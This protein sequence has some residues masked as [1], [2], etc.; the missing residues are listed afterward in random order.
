MLAAKINYHTAM[1]TSFTFCS[2]GILSLA[3]WLGTAPVSRADTNFVVTTPNFIYELN[4]VPPP[5]APGSWTN[6]CEPLTLT[7]GQTVTFNMQASFFHPM[8][9]ATNAATSSLDPPANFAYD[10]ASPQDIASGPITLTLSASGFPST[11][12]Y[13]C[14]V[15]GFYGVITVV[16]ASGGGPPPPPN[17]IVSLSVT[18]NIVMVSTG[19]NTS[20]ILVPQFSSNLLSGTWAP[21]PSYTN[22][23]ANGTNVTVFDRLDPICGPNVFLRVSQQPPP[24]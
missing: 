16:P 13:Q 22:T 6:N 20:Y 1:K 24:N 2:A 17:Q 14:N 23:F 4:G 8:V 12:Y 18:T 10:G 5:G 9:I 21:V 15:H 11:L 19:T 7:A 3:L